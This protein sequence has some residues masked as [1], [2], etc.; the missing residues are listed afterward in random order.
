MKSLTLLSSSQC[1]DGSNEVFSHP[2]TSTNTAMKFSVFRPPQARC[3]RVPVVYWL[4]GLTCTEENFMAKAGAQRVASRLGIMIVAP[5]TSPRGAGIE[6]EGKNWD[7]GLGAG[8]YVDATEPPWSKH[9]R[10]DSYVTQELR[11][12]VENNFPV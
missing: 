3:K 12:I 5:D 1:F 6:G 10:M 11:S 2:S 8:F 7:F 4:S 9:Y